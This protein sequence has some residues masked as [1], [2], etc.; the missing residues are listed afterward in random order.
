MIV[1][2]KSYKTLN[3]LPSNH[4]VQFKYLHAKHR[5]IFQ[6][7]IKLFIHKLWNATLV[8]KHLM[9]IVKQNIQNWWFLNS[10]N[11][12]LIFQKCQTEIDNETAWHPC[13]SLTRRGDFWLQVTFAR[14]AI[15]SSIILHL[16]TDGTSPFSTD[17][18]NVT[19]ELIDTND[20][21]HIAGEEVLLRCKDNP[22][23][24]DIKHD[25]SQPFF[26]TKSKS[27]SHQY[28]LI[29]LFQWIAFL[30]DILNS[31]FD[32]TIAYH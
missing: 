16:G 24:V 2:F 7:I 26:R 4:L 22:V 14:P 27:R 12:N 30:V 32:S 25:L 28:I 18:K 17:V 13:G 8:T 29:K 20:V 11:T 10:V 23:Y 15:A 31:Y 19:I 3:L 9:L 6:N 5:W 21:V 1:R